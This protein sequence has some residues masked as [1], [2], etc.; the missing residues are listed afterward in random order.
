MSSQ[1]DSATR[2]RNRRQCRQRSASDSVSNVTRRPIRAHICARKLWKQP[3]VPS[4]PSVVTLTRVVIPSVRS[5]SRSY[6]LA[7]RYLPRRGP[8]GESPENPTNRPSSVTANSHALRVTGKHSVVSPPCASSLLTAERASPCIEGAVVD[9]HVGLAV[10][11]AGNDFGTGRGKYDPS[12]GGADRQGIQCRPARTVQS[13]RLFPRDTFSN[14][15]ALSSSKDAV[16]VR[17]AI[18]YVDVR[19][20]PQYSWPGT[21]ELPAHSITR[22]S[23]TRRAQAGFRSGV[24]SD[25]VPSGAGPKPFVWCVCR[26]CT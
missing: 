3:L 7:V 11:V 24:V 25:G 23:T 14:A 16:I 20:S 19:M 15:E 17:V 13:T 6:C 18:T 1:P 5:A 21:S 12:P 2:T 9:E 10:R 4:E 22:R 26:S 8:Q